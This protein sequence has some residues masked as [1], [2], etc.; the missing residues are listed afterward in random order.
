MPSYGE[1]IAAARGHAA[2]S[3]AELAFALSNRLGRALP[4]DIVSKWERNK[5]LP[6][7]DEW[8]A[9]ADELGVAVDD[10]LRPSPRVAA[11]AAAVESAA[12]AAAGEM[13]DRRQ[14]E[15]RRGKR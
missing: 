9:L 13:E 5:R 15:R 11:E 8:V 6:R 1:R 10:L 14:R 12:V 3:Q 2:L 7:E 4:S